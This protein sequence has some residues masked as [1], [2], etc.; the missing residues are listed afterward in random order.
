MRS[1]VE[2]Y[3]DRPDEWLPLAH[4][5]HTNR[6]SLQLRRDLPGSESQRLGDE[7]VAK[8][9]RTRATV[10]GTDTL[11]PINVLFGRLAFLR[12]LF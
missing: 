3:R 6:A 5:E 9:T 2:E 10:T 12:R 1:D 11:A 8:E 4:S 7:R